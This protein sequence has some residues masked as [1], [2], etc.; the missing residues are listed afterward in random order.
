MLGCEK[1]YVMLFAEQPGY[2][3]VHVHVVPRM[4]WFGETERSAASVRF[5]RAPEE[6][7][8]STEE[9]ERLAGAIGRMMLE[10]PP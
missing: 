1:T 7:W 6:E 5:L 8:V 9:R 2:G 4:P 10:Q 3:H